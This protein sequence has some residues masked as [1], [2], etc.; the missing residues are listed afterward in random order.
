MFCNLLGDGFLYRYRS[1]G[2]N[3]QDKI[4][5]WKTYRRRSCKGNESVRGEVGV[6]GVEDEADDSDEPL[7]DVV[8]AVGQTFREVE[9]VTHPHG[10]LKHS[11]CILNVGMCGAPQQQS[12]LT[13][14]AMGVIRGW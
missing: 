12:L 2:K 14:V 3:C 5:D 1:F 6:V 13:I 8:V 4:F 9:E 11:N 10:D 7:P